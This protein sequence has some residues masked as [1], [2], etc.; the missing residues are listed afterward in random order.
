MDKVS[1]FC[2]V[3]PGQ[4]LGVHNVSST[5]HVPLLL[6]DQGMLEFLSKRLNLG[7]VKV[8]EEMKVKGADLMGRWRALTIG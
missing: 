8:E 6:R 4:V 7:D 5:Y 3:T 2:H 1:M